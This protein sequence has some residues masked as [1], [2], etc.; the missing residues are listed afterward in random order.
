MEGN[1]CN[2]LQSDSL[3]IYLLYYLEILGYFFYRIFCSSIADVL[4]VIEFM[5]YLIINC[6][7]H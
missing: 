7:L 2:S 6:Q 5:E 1:F 3:Q 4:V